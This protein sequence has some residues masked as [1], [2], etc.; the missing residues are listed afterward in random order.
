MNE[1]KWNS[2]FNLGVE[3][4]D[5]AHQKLFSIVGKLLALNEEPEKQQYACREGIKYFKNYSVKHFA[6]EEAYMQSVNYSG[7]D[8]HRKLHDNMRDRTIP[9]LE[10]ELERQN[11]SVESVRHFLGICIG[12]LNGHV[13]IEDHAITGR[14]PNKWVHGPSDDE[15]ASLEKAVIQAAQ[16]M[17]RLDAHIVSE[18]YSGEDFCSGDIMC[19]RMTYRSGTGER[20]RVFLVYEQRLILGILSEML[21]RQ[22]NTAD[23]TV[24][25]AVKILSQKYIGR[26]GSH[27]PPQSGNEIEKNDIL[28]FEQFLHM[29]DK[30]YPPYSLLFGTGGRGY[31]ALCI[32]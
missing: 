3:E 19:Y 32:V 23:R 28:T 27:F 10:E 16:D 31:F 29:F 7:Y 8:M 24:I 2:R 6:Q 15:K 5:K 22:I 9:A 18:N 20:I 25:Y 1:V 13:M 21:G 30:E 17:F 14:V 12:W 11:Y 26:I 4:I